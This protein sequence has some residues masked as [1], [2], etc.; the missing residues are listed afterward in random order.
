MENDH[1]ISWSEVKI[2]EVEFDYLQR[3]FTE[4]WHINEKPQVPNRNDGLSFP[5]VYRKLRNSHY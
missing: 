3:L 1:L 5:A 2:L 4:S